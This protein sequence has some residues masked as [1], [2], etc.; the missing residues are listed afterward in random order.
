MSGVF[1]FN[2][3]HDRESASDGVSRYGFYLRNSHPQFA[4]WD[5]P[6]AVTADP[7]L[8][9]QMAWLV[10]SRPVMTPP[11]LDWDVERLQEVTCSSSEYND[12]LIVR[13]QLAVP[14]PEPLHGLRGFRSWTRGSSWAGRSS[15]CPPLDD[16]IARRPAMLT[17]TTLLFHIPT[18]DL[19]VPRNAPAELSVQDAKASIKRLGSILEERLAPV[20]EALS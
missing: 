5:D 20:L 14:D 17:S 3:A 11:Y 16:D 12:G 7:V 10:A 4:D 19:Y 8:F 1:R 6:Q 18:S 2:D 9:T 15:Y 13:I